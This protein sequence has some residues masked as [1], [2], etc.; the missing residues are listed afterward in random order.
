MN[1]NFVIKQ[2]NRLGKLLP[3]VYKDI[4]KSNSI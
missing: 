3:S 4:N 1:R 2:Q